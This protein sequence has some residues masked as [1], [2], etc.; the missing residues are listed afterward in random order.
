MATCEGTKPIF[1]FFSFHLLNYLLVSFFV[2]V[3]FSLS[4]SFL[5]PL[6]SSFFYSSVV[7]FVVIKFIVLLF[8]FFVKLGKETVWL[9]LLKPNCNLP[10]PSEPREKNQV[11]TH[12]QNVTLPF[13]RI[14]REMTLKRV[15]YS[16]AEELKLY[17]IGSEEEIR[18]VQ[19][20]LPGGWFFEKKLFVLQTNTRIASTKIHQQSKTS[21]Q[22]Q[23][24]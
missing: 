15:Q 10:F 20:P 2:R 1:C 23:R 11:G 16:P 3:V 17:W 8:L 5:L 7:S 18:S 9:L 22:R 19:K 24:R 14:Q 6:F 4:L 12:K 21:Y 13:S